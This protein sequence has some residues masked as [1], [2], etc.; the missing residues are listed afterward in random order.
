MTDLIPALPP[1][2]IIVWRRGGYEIAL[3]EDG[4]MLRVY[5]ERTFEPAEVAKLIELFSA[6]STAVAH[7]DTFTAPKPPTR[8]E[9][10]A[11]AWEDREREAARRAQ[12]A[13][14]AEFDTTPTTSIPF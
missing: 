2:D 10:G 1:A 6:V 5:R 7:G 4:P 11:L 9:I 8:E 14:A 3:N 12:R 13:I